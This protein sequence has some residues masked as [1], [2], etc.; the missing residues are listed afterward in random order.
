MAELTNLEKA[1]TV[2]AHS[3]WGYW[4]AALRDEMMRVAQTPEDG[5]LKDEALIKLGQM[6]AYARM[7][8]M[9]KETDEYGGEA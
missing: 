9:I 3:M 8:D 6:K 4:K 1:T 2:R 7:H 5:D